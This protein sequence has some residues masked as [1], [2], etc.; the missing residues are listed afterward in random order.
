MSPERMHSLHQIRLH[1]ELG[2]NLKAG[3][4]IVCDSERNIAGYGCEGNTILV[5]I[6][7]P[8][9]HESVM[10]WI[11][12]IAIMMRSPVWPGIRK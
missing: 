2:V 11:V 3:F 5:R 12:A 8:T 1:N 10:A 4:E 7:H 6:M 9:P